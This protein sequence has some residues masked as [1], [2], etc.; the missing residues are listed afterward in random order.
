MNTSRRALAG[1][2][3]SSLV[4]VLSACGSSTSMSG[5]APAGTAVARGAASLTGIS[6]STRMICATEV[7]KDIGVA[8]GVEPV[9]PLAPV[10]RDHRYS[11][12]YE[13]AQGVL[14]L[15]VKQLSDE[16]ATHRYLE[17]LA[18]RLGKRRVLN[19]LG[20]EAFTTTN[21]SVVVNKDNKVLVVDVHGLPAQFGTPADTRANVGITVA[22]TIMGCWTEA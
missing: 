12:E 15:S 6:E 10:W 1:L 18:T 2:L 11:C 9:R 16:R 14:R 3:V 13:Y 17:T 4:I 21:H 7:R 8:L 5:A 20:Q 19:G 22:A